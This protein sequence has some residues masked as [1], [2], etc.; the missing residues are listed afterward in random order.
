MSVPAMS[1]HRAMADP[2]AWDESLLRRYAI[3]GRRYTSYPTPSAFQEDFGEVDYQAALARSNAGARPLSVYVHIPFCRT[4][5]HYCASNK[6]AARANRLAEPYLSRLD[7]EMVL[8]RQRL[9]T[10]R[11]VQQLHWGGGTPTFLSLDQMSDLIDR[12]DARFGLSGARDR[13]YAIDI[14]PREADVLPCATCRR[15]ASTA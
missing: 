5:C 1:V 8:I 7:R 3:G 13:D 12:L 6:V 9:D 10:A 14:D 2:F 11:E 4:I 15:W